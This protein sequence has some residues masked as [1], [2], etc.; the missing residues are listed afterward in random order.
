LLPTKHLP[1]IEIAPANRR[2]DLVPHRNSGRAIK[3]ISLHQQLNR[4]TVRTIRERRDHLRAPNT[5]LPLN[6]KQHRSPGI[7]GIETLMQRKMSRPQ[8][9]QRPAGTICELLS[10]GEGEGLAS[11]LYNLVAVLVDDVEGVAG[12]RPH[13]FFHYQHGL[14]GHAVGG[15]HAEG[16]GEGRELAV[17][18][19][20][21]LYSF[22]FG[23]IRRVRGSGEGLVGG[24]IF[25]LRCTEGKHL[26]FSR[27]SRRVYMP[28][29]HPIVPSAK[30]FS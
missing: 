12:E 9:K 5:K 29:H 23:G 13:L 8:T 22:S 6:L 28:I 16:W 14:P 30:S 4:R 7:L 1:H 20:Y 18:L 11:A 10:V 2:N 26:S 15:V 21:R 17:H 19:V 24:L 3:P 27:W 25:E